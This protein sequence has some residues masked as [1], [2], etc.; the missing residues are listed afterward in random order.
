MTQYA[1]AQA[2]HPKDLHSNLNLGHK[3]QWRFSLIL[4]TTYAYCFFSLALST[5]LSSDWS[6]NYSSS[7]FEKCLARTVGSPVNK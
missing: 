2:F 3:V 4:V 5:C 7:V 6:I 1:S